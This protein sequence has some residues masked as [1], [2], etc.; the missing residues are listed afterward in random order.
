MAAAANVSPASPAGSVKSSR[1]VN[2][3]GRPKRPRTLAEYIHDALFPPEP[4]EDRRKLRL[5]VTDPTRVL[6]GSKPAGSQRRPSADDIYAFVSRSSPT[7]PRGPGLEEVDIGRLAP[8]PK[9]TSPATDARLGGAA[10]AAAGSASTASIVSRHKRSKSTSAAHASP[11]LPL[12]GSGPGSPKGTRYDWLS[13]FRAK[14]R[15]AAGATS[16]VKVRSVSY[17]NERLADDAHMLSVEEWVSVHCDVTMARVMLEHPSSNT[18]QMPPIDAMGP[19]RRSK[20]QM[21]MS[22][23]VALKKGTEPGSKIA[24]ASASKATAVL[25]EAQFYGTDDDFLMKSTVRSFIALTT[26]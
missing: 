18:G 12:P 7:E 9:T 5:V 19:R 20:G 22:Q 24:V 16:K 11:T 1:A 21:E 6:D 15:R 2:L 25:Y 17:R 4:V 14:S 13:E 8:P 3:F 10:T 23:L 26:G